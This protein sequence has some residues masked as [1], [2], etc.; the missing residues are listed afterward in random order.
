MY[1]CSHSPLLHY[2]VVM[3]SYVTNVV[4]CFK[5]V[6]GHILYTLVCIYTMYICSHSPLLHYSV[7]MTSYVTNV[8]LCFKSYTIYTCMYIHLF[9][10]TITTLHGCNEFI[11]NMYYSV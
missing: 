8:V 1:I 2:S 3:T 6:S 9:T 11:Y 5:C 4:L 7:V 10:F